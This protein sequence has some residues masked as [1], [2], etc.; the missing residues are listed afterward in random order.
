M[1]AA[2]GI[3]LDDEDFSWQFRGVASDHVNIF[4]LFEREKMV[5]VMETMMD[6]LESDEATVTRCW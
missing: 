3:E 1:Q 5:A 4:M 6:S 2:T